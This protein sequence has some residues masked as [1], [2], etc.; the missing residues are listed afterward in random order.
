MGDV[1]GKLFSPACA[2]NA[3]PIRAVLSEVL[4]STGTIMELGCGT[5][6]HAVHFARSFPAL[7]WQPVD[8]PGTLESVRA[9]RLEAD[10][11]NLAEPVEFDL[12]D[13]APPIES[14]EALVSMNVLHIAPWEAGQRLF[15][16]AE[17]LLPRGGVV[18]LYGPYR[19]A[20]RP[21]EPS[22]EAFDQSLRSR[23][24]GSGIRDFEAVDEIAQTHGFTLAGD[25]AMPANNRSLWWVKTG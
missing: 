4:P 11:P 21:L 8:R 18:Y 1:T 19:Y 15:M 17:R 25:R 16:H 9:Y 13:D 10:L 2:R 3:E 5:G 6:Q 7:T 23:G 12:F 24:C 22:N 20:D 14:A